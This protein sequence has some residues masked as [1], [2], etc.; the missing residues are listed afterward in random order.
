LAW[1]TPDLWTIV[2]LGI[3]PSMATSTAESLPGL[4][5][6]WL[7]RSG[8]LPRSLRSRSWCPKFRFLIR[9]VFQRQQH[10]DDRDTGSCDML[11]Y[12]YS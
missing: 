10:Q 6:E 11:S 5:R 7:G 1:A 4:L 3:Y 12:R 9:G 2:Y 8:V